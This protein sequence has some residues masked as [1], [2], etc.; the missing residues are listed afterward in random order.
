MCLWN[1][2]SFPPTSW[3]LL[4]KS[5]LLFL[6]KKYACETEELM[7]LRRKRAFLFVWC[8][9]NQPVSH[10]PNAESLF[11]MMILGGR[12]HSLADWSQVE[13]EVLTAR[14]L[15]F[16]FI[17]WV[18]LMWKSLQMN[19]Y[20]ALHYHFY[21]LI[22]LTITLCNYLR[23]MW[24]LP[25]ADICTYN[26]HICMKYVASS[27][28]KKHTNLFSI[29]VANTKRQACILCNRERRV[30]GLYNSYPQMSQGVFI[31]RSEEK[32]SILQLTLYKC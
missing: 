30:C 4:H 22:L 25:T 11:C 21:Q 31:L 7:Q 9:I 2:S 24:V 26:C 1:N 8:S 32:N 18:K 20:R 15:M 29:Q 13:F 19:T 10:I 23:W 17:N 5:H 27:R 28:E 16:R 12:K 3:S 14:G 6:L